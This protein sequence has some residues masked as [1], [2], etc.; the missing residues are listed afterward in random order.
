MTEIVRGAERLGPRVRKVTPMPDYQL[1]LAFTNGEERMFDAADLLNLPAFAPL[2]DEAFF[3]LV[4]VEF[5]TVCWPD[6]IDYCPDTL[7]AESVPCI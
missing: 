6:D 3:R 7:Y 4:R 1:R 5:G 2:R